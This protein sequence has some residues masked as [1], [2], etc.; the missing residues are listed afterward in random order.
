M[1][2]DLA[3][4]GIPAGQ[5]H[6]NEG[7]LDASHRAFI[8]APRITLV[9]PSFNQG[10]FIEET[11]L[12]VLS[13][14]Y[15]NLDYIIIDGG[16][17]DQSVEIIKKYQKHLAYWVS[18][19]DG[20]Q[21][22]AINKGMKTATGELCGWLCSDDLLQPGALAVVG[23]YFATHPECDWVVGGDSGLHFR[24]GNPYQRTASY[25]SG[26]LI[27]FWDTGPD[28]HTC[29]PQ[30]S[31]FW[32]GSLWGS[33]GGLVESCH[34][35]MDYD[36]WLRFEE[37]CRPHV[38]SEVLSFSRQHDKCKSVMQRPQQL[39]E[40]MASAYRA[41]GRRGMSPVELN[42]RMLASIYRRR[43]ARM[44]YC[45]S[46]GWPGGAIRESVSLVF[47]CVRVWR[48]SGRVAIMLGD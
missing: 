42:R 16:S 34:L 22:H 45:L 46:T 25:T 36:L 24:S 40:K 18:E 33:V 28:R 37:A 12:S 43:H 27:E 48:A 47:D 26:T 44:Q 35:A 2:G 3:P 32:R 11:I 23:K 13:Q 29:I 30:P 15:P 20:G 4:T 14:D 21:S 39:R 7:P 9:T 10:E 31:T 41:A 1:S 17:T 19:R 5:S 8:R 6:A 38:L